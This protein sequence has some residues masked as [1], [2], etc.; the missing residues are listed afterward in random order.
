MIAL[1]IKFSDAKRFWRGRKTLSVAKIYLK[2]RKVGAMNA[3]RRYKFNAAARRASL[4]G[5][6]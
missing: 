1:D 6:A 4:A 3:E 2:F 5:G